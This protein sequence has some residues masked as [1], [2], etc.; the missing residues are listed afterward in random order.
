MRQ[1]RIHNIDSRDELDD[2]RDN[3]DEHTSFGR[4]QVHYAEFS[5]FHYVVV[6]LA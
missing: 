4:T 1:Y 3:R 6:S 2:Y 5:M